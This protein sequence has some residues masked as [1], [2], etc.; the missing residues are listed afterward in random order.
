MF[1]KSKP[2]YDWLIAG[3]GNP[4]MQYENT[5]HNIGFMAVDKL[6]EKEKFEFSKNKFDA[7]CGEFNLKD[8]RILVIKPQTFM[9]NSGAAV[10]KAALFYKI[11]LDRVVIIHDDISL[12][13]GK[14]RMRR[15]GSHGGHNGMKDIIELSGK[16]DIMRIKMGVGAKP[17][18]DYDLASWVLGKFPKEEQEN[19][20]KALDISVKAIKEIIARGIDSAMNKFNS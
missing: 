13:V 19:L 20:E 18:P 2:T 16:D 6:A 14:I 5:R 11:P 7:V 10:T 4:G 15:K 9:N 1:F 3:L 8:N 12:P 17:H